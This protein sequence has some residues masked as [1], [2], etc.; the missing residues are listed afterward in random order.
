MMDR[1]KVLRIVPLILS[2]LL[3]GAHFLRGGHLFIM[4]LCVAAPLLLLLRKRAV[5]IG[6]QVMLAVAAVEWLR[7]AMQIAEE[8]AAS[9]APVTRMYVILGS[10][11]AFTLLSA[12]PLFGLAGTGARGLAV[13]SSTLPGPRIRETNDPISSAS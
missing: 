5:T 7:T 3:I 10:V 6:I 4:L 9:G 12:V 11:A 1:M 2:A 8:R 13:E